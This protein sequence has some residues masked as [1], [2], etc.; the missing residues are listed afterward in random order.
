M[1]TLE[2][3]VFKLSNENV[4]IIYSAQGNAGQPALTYEDPELDKTFQGSDIRVLV[5]EIGTLVTVTLDM[6]VDA[7][8]TLLS[9]LLPSVTVPQADSP[10]AIKTKAIVTRFTKVIGTN[11]P[12]AAQTY[13]VESLHGTGE[14]VFVTTAVAA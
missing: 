9:V 6:T 14:F 1:Q 11:L 5:T 4:R 10:I 12:G 2:A 3:N 13:R 7:G 8:A